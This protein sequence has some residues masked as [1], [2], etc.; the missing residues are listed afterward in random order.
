MSEEERE[1]YRI[2]F[3]ELESKYL[4][5]AG[6][7]RDHLANFF[8]E[9]NIAVFDVVYRIKKIESFLEKITRKNYKNPLEE[10]D[11]ICGLRIIYYYNRDFQ[12]IVNILSSEFEVKQSI[13]K[14]DELSIDRF[15][16]RS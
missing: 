4:S 5:I 3:K 8:V 9:A 14:E 12:K 11:D 1:Q 10:I 7:L 2:H 16:Y 6:T 13:P 15:G